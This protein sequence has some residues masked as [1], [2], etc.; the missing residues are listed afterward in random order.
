MNLSNGALRESEAAIIPANRALWV[1]LEQK[2]LHKEDALMPDVTLEPLD[3]DRSWKGSSKPL[4][5][6]NA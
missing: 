1:S 5:A 2:S 4:T 6:G 3:L